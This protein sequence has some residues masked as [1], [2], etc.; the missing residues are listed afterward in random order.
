MATKNRFKIPV[1]K[2]PECR[3]VKANQEGIVVVIHKRGC[4][5]GIKNAMLRGGIHREMNIA[6]RMQDIYSA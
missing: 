4:P 1:Y 5:T 3:G 2:C 6:K